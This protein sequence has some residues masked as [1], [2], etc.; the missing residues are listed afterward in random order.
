M[1]FRKLASKRHQRIGHFEKLECRRVLATEGELVTIERSLDTSAISGNISG[2]ITW[3]D[4][5]SSVAQIVNQPGAG[6]L[7]IRFDYSLD[8]TGFFASQSRRDLLQLAAD[9]LITK[10]ADNLTAIT[11][12][13]VNSWNASFQN[14]TTGQMTSLQNLTV[15]A[16]ELVIYVGARALSGSTLALASIGGYSAS[17]TQSFLDTVRARG[18]AGA[19]ASTPTDFG[20]WG[21]SIAFQS[22][23][24]W[25][26]SNSTTGLDS[27]ESDFL[28]AAIHELCHVMGFGTAPSWATFLSGTQFVGNNAKGK[29]DLGGNIPTDSIRVHWIEGTKDGGQETLMDPTLSKG[30][31][32]ALTRLDLAGLQDIG[33]TLIEPTATIRGSHTFADNG[34]FDVDVQLVGARSGVGGWSQTLSITNAAPNLAAIS[35]FNVVAGVPLVVP[36]LGTFTDLGY[37]NPQDSPPTLE[38]FTYRIEW[39]DGTAAQSGNATVESMGKAGTA[40]KGFFDASHV[41][42]APGTYN[43]LAR[44][45][46][47]DGGTNTRNF[48]VNVQ[49]AP[50][51]T[52]SVSKSVVDENAGLRATILTVRRTGNSPGALTVN[53]SSSDTSELRLP[54]TTTIPSG[55]SEV[56]VDIEAVDD[57]LLDGNIMVTITASALG[58]GNGTTQVEVADYEVISGTVNQANVNENVGSSLLTW[59][60]SRSNTDQSL[61][62]VLQLSSSDTTELVV[63]ATATIPAGSPSITIPLVVQDDSILDGT[64]TV[65]LLASA[66]GYRSNVNIVS[67]LDVESLQL[68]VDRAQL[69]EQT[70]VDTTR[71][72]VNLSFPA[73]AGGYVVQLTPSKTGQLSLPSSV[74]VPSGAQS[75]QF[76]LS[77]VDDFAVEGT[78]SVELLAAGTGVSSAAV[79]LWIEDNDEPLWQNPVDKW[80]TDLNRVFNAMDALVIINNLNRYGSRY[81]R[82]GVDLPSPPYVDA[83]GDG[84]VNA[85]DAL[86]VIN[87]LNRRFSA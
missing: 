34:S 78:M 39:G 60:L 3:N 35:N 38:R 67:V 28:S 14:P 22:T 8:T 16:N 23:A 12:G 47:D 55:A 24:N 41:Y 11:P 86:M 10:F 46:D 5:T 51:L 71:A 9:T 4:G 87:E 68:I 7:K 29:Y 75:V 73:P 44:V 6:P 18:Q 72:T 61:P 85:I 36:K 26:F 32:K 48:T 31:R 81:L 40:T 19:L 33:W 63:P 17:G 42:A 52:L 62:L 43:V 76:D 77:A 30:V 45:T 53:L 74:T 37:D 79:D 21:G 49:A 59:T 20:P 84:I 1:V 25:H 54:L 50:Q 65:T 15:A 2:T 83:N 66:A 56:Q 69:N 27:T 82:P 13:G 57:S 80:D 58:F 70:P 64:I